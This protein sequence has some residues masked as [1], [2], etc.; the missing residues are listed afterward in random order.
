[1]LF[2]KKILSSSVALALVGSAI[3]AF[4]QD[5]AQIEEVIVEGGIRASLKRAMDIK[6]DSAGVA[7]AISAED[8][9]KFPDTNLAES[10]QR[11]TGVSIDRQRGEGSQVTVRGFGPEYNLVTLNGRQMPTH[12]GTNR[13]F[14]F[15]DLASEGISAVVVHKTGNAAAATG[16]VGSTINIIT[17]KPL[18]AGEIATFGAKMAMD[19]STETGDDVT[20]EFSGLYSNT[21]ADDTVGIAISASSQRR[22]NAVNIASIGGW[23][24]NA[25]DTEG[26]W[27]SVP[28]NDAQ[29]NRPTDAAANMSI[30]QSNA[31]NLSEYESE[32]ING[33]LTLQWAPSETVTATVDYTY[34]EFDLDRTYSDLSAWYNL[35]NNVQSSVWDDGMIASPIMYSEASPNSD[36]AMGVGHDG[37]KTE[38]DSFGLNLEWQVNEQ[39][40]LAFDYHD[41]G[42]EQGANN[43][44]GTSSLVT[45]ASFNRV[46]T[47][48]YFDQDMPI[49]Q[50]GLNSGADGADRPLYKDDM[51]ITGSVFSNAYSKMDIEQ[52]RII[53]KFDADD[54]TTIDFGIELTEV[55]NRT[56][57]KSVE[58]GTWGGI[59]DPGYISDILV[60]SSMANS[61]DQVSGGNDPRR[62]TEYFSTT[63]EQIVELAEALPLPASQTVGDCGT[64]Y[65]ASTA[66]DV[67]KRTTEETTAAYV[68]INHETEFNAMPISL[69]AGLRYEST[70]VTSAARAPTY[71]DVYWE[72]G[73]EFYLVQGTDVAFDNYEG[74]YDLMLPNLDINIDLRDD[75]VLRASVSKTVTRPSYESIK[76]GV[77]VDGQTFKFRDARAA[78]GDPSLKPIEAENF[79]LS[80][81]WYY[82][83]AD[84]LSFGYYEKTVDNFIGNGFKTMA[85]FGLNDP[86]S[87]GLYAETAAAEG[88]D[89][90]SQYTA[91]GDAMS[92][93]FDADGRYYGT[94]ANDP[95]T[96]TVAV[97][98][99]EKTAKV[100]GIE[101]NWQHNFGETGYGF[102]VNATIANADVAFD[103]LALETQFVLNGLSDS[104]NL[105]GFYDKGGFQA[106]FAYNWRDKFLAGIG[107][108]QGSSAINP[109]NI[110]AYGQ[111]DISASYEVNENLT[112]FLD[113]INVTESDF[114]VYGREELQVLQAGQT[115]ARYN[116]GVR[117]TF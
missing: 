58:R 35:G 10:L 111:L 15:G 25:G 82:G 76:G 43:P 117:Y 28:S 93:A 92:A 41:S 104:A 90:G 87:G 56:T 107:Q 79:D 24:T 114:R 89:P 31:Y 49:L 116:L 106:R 7:D 4:A 74:T 78:G 112:V 19:T 105:I 36:F 34:S 108:G 101:V 20:P 97:P 44:F 22:N 37:A 13:S 29:V 38:N 30:P 75:L 69:R 55:S 70:D 45:M 62:Q 54:A 14:D 26:T 48:T 80:I 2:K 11:V 1:M 96:F 95:L 57:S 63:L 39:L 88:L 27:T 53:G 113:G 91:I 46:Q 72:G 99:N 3:P 47:T 51:I 23:H 42:S 12:N 73:N 60:R 65:C 16:G 67:D 85:L 68:Q 81:E 33:Q 18:E 84:Y 59:S 64:A 94:S 86:A 66:W 32:R 9:G 103:P 110:R 71:D 52:S 17:T 61:F 40:S 100:D 5:G 83:D 102:I 6:R 8:M 115:G 98:T 50:L 109:T 21:F 77:T